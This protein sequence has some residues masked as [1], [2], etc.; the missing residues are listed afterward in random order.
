MT[1]PKE[2]LPHLAMKDLTLGEP[3]YDMT[4]HKGS[5]C[6]GCHTIDMK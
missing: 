2:F 5:G 4:T 3:P 6:G 1:D